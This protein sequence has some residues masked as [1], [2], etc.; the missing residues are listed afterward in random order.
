MA[1]F[2]SLLQDKLVK[3][4]YGAM[5][6]PERSKLAELFP[7]PPGLNRANSFE[8]PVP[9]LRALLSSKEFESHFARSGELADVIIRINSNWKP[10]DFNTGVSLQPAPATS[11]YSVV[12]HEVG[13]GLGFISGIDEDYSSTKVFR[14]SP[15]DLYRFGGDQQ[16]N[17]DFR[18]TPRYFGIDPKVAHIWF[19]PYP[20]DGRVK[21]PAFSQGQA[22]D[23]FQARHWKD[24]YDEKARRWSPY[25]GVMDPSIYGSLPCALT[26]PDVRAIS[27]L[28]YRVTLFAKPVLYGL[29]QKPLASATYF[30]VAGQLLLA[31]TI[32]YL[33]VSSSGSYHLSRSKS[34]AYMTEEEAKTDIGQFVKARMNFF[35]PIHWTANQRFPLLNSARRWYIYARNRN[36]D[37]GT[38]PPAWPF[39]ELLLTPQVCSFLAGPWSDPLLF[40]GDWL[41][42]PVARD[43]HWEL[44]TAAATAARSP[45]PD[46]AALADIRDQIQP[47]PPMPKAEI[48]SP[49]PNTS[50]HASASKK[51]RKSRAVSKRN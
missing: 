20:I 49:K 37:S 35:N 5:I 1:D 15:L 44:N 8:V 30:G 33:F 32:E 24:D 12:T 17:I 27:R 51:R 38:L 47:K 4:G 43:N 45:S 46:F 40:N 22:V 3:L 28:G 16:S 14:P 50:T 31:N 7:P 29:W 21:T 34:A 26:L 42:V 41:H 11:L 6:F 9:I 25:M 39:F 19:D 48:S 2:V 23:G 18:T 10:N 13:H 36:D